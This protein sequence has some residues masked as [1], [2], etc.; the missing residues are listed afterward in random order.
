MKRIGFKIVGLLFLA[1]FLFTGCSN[2]DKKLEATL[3]EGTGI[4]T[5]VTKEGEGKIIFF[6]DGMAKADDEG[7]VNATYEIKKDGT[8]IRMK[9]VDSDVYTTMENIEIESDKVIKVDLSKNGKAA[10]EPCKLVK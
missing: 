9:I 4:W 5:F 3:T 8:E 2:K 7:E 10:T 6:E 1:L